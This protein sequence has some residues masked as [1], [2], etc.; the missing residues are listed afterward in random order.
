MQSSKEYCSPGTDIDAEVHWSPV[1]ESVPV[2][3]LI[4]ITK[5][6]EAD[7]VDVWDEKYLVKYQ[8]I[9]EDYKNKYMGKS[10]R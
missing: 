4:K 7:I 1:Q 9:T 2:H 10:K 5:N 6:K 8:A 3:I